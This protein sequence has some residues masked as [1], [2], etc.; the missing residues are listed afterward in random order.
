MSLA[1]STCVL[2]ISLMYLVNEA[3]FLN[4]TFLLVL[5]ASASTSA[6][7][8]TVIVLFTRIYASLESQKLDFNIVVLNLI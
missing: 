5:F 6:V 1:L 4:I 8:L 2:L 3:Q 7:L